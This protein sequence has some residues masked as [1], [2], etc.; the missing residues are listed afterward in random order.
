VPA[1]FQ[2]F[3]PLLLIVFLLL[4]V[5]PTIFKHHSS[6]GLTSKELSQETIAAT[7]K[8]D[9]LQREFRTAHKGYTGSVADLL[10]LDH[11][12][13]KALGDGVVIALDVSTDKQT[14]YAQ[15]ASSVIQLTRARE[16][17][18]MI[19]KSCLVVKSSSGVACP[20]PPAKKTT[21][22][23]TSTATTTTSSG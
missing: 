19:S 14:Y 22:T 3:L 6:K 4:F 15:V 9:A 23:T 1:N 5:L 11:S 21:S 12:L 2:K 7:T 8:V 10:G 17:D 18:K 20:Q 16:G 13:G